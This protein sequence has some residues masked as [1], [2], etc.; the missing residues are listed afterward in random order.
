MTEVNYDYSKIDQPEVLRIMFHPRREM[1][2]P[3]A[4][5]S[6][7]DIDIKVDDDAQVHARF[8]LGAKENPN[9]LFFHGNGEIVSDYDEIGPFYNKYGMNFLAVDYRGYGRSTGSPTAT[10]MLTD[11]HISL[12][13]VKDWLKSAGYTGPLIIMGRS[14]GSATAIDLAASHPDEIAGLIIESGFATTLPLLMRLGVDTAGLGITEED[15][16]RNV[17]KI[18]TITKPTLLIHGQHDEIIPVNE[19]GILQAQSGARA[20]ELQIVPKASHNTILVQAGE[21]Y[22]SIIK[23]F[24]DKLS[25]IR[26]VRRRKKN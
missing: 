16:F 6:G 2:S 10:S 20:K 13:A 14:L 12:A 5:E 4:P 3:A 19:A 7:V 15:G 23:R 9:I 26:A 1:S 22:F 17:R 24:T 18:S 11:A 25:G 21:M 8:H